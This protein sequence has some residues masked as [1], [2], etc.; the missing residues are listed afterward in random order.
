VIIALSCSKQLGLQSLYE[1][2][3]R[4]VFPEMKRQGLQNSAKIEW[5]PPED[6]S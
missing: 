1:A 2:V 6:K 4:A 3:E 5:I